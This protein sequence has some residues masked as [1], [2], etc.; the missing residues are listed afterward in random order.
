[1]RILLT[2]PLTAL[3]I[4]CGGDSTTDRAG[5]PPAD[6]PPSA[7][8]TVTIADFEFGA[9]VTVAPGTTVTFTNT[10]S[11]PHNAVGDDFKTADLEWGERDT[12]TFDQAGTYDYVCTFHPFMKGSIVVR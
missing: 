12:V 6:A 3:L 9:P 11:A 8:K 5:T 4:G 7:V 2:I 10:D 1:M